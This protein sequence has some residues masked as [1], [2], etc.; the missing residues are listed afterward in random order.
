M[1]TYSTVSVSRRIPCLSK[2]V[3]FLIRFLIVFFHR[4]HNHSF[5]YNDWMDARIARS[6]KDIENTGH[7]EKRQRGE[8]FLQTDLHARKNDFHTS[9]RPND[10]AK[11][12]HLKDHSGQIETSFGPFRKAILAGLLPLP[13]GKTTFREVESKKGKHSRASLAGAKIQ[14]DRGEC[15]CDANSLD[16]SFGAN[17]GKRP[18]VPAP[19]AT[20]N[21]FK[22]CGGHRIVRHPP[23]NLECTTCR[24]I[25]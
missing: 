12:P 17:G 19:P 16:I 2:H 18:T 9:S 24:S 14:K 3:I 4:R 8:I 1:R 7:G 15:K 10:K 25:A 5:T 20:D 22:E 6:I 23:L 11:E 21:H 13:A